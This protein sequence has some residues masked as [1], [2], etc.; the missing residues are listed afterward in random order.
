MLQS[1]YK[2]DLKILLHIANALR[3]FIRGTQLAI[4]Y[5]VIMRYFVNHKLLYTYIPLTQHQFVSFF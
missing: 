4:H 1:N 2:T 5:N 3:Q